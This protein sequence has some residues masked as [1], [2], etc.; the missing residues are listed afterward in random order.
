[1]EQSQKDTTVA[2]V[3]CLILCALI[4]I[5]GY[6]ET[7]RPLKATFC[8]IIGL[9][10]RWRSPPLPLAILTFDDHFLP[11]LIGLAIDFGVHLITRYEE[12]LRQGHSEQ[13]AMRTRLSLPAKE[14]LPEH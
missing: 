2:S 11:I 13:V 3:A 12:E 9:G 4:F 10:I 5:Y 6:Q 14:S 7:G 8:L 1:M